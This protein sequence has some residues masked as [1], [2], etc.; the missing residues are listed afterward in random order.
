MTALKILVG[1]YPGRERPEKILGGL[2]W[3]WERLRSD[4]PISEEAYAQGIKA[5]CEADKRLKTFYAAHRHER[6]I[7]E[8]LVV[9]LSYLA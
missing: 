7:L 2:L 1:L 3:Q 5:L 4:K 8:A 9:K 6:L